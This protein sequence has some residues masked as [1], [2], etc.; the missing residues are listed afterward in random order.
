MKY[1]ILLSI[2]ILFTSCGSNAKIS[3]DKSAQSWN[4]FNY[5]EIN[6]VNKASEVEGGI[7]YDRIVP[8]PHQLINESILGVL[9]T[10]YWSPSDSIP[11]VTK[12]NYTIEDVKGISAK[13]GSVPEISIFYSSRWVEQVSKK[14]GD[15]KVLYET[16]GVLYHELVH[17]YQLEPQGIG[18][19]GNNKTFFAFIEGV[20]DA[21][22]AIN[23][24]FPAENRKAGGN[25]MDG[26]QTTGF[27]LEWLTTK[28]TDFLRKFNKSALE[29]I[30]WSFD[31]AI[32]HVLGEQYTIEGVWNQYQSFLKD[33]QKNKSTI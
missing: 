8:K 30:P 11:I 18:S 3:S 22:R 28:D 9:K 1:I 16:K 33:E 25:W 26:Y 20:A 19:Y 5:P 6:I 4:T 23:G 31:G 13:G 10:L 14:G 32:K 7:I 21:V 27:F 17:G 15:A 2:S 29:V 24:Y 12:I